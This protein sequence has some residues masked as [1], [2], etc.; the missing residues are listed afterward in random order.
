MPRP[1]AQVQPYVE[2][3]GAETAVTFLLA[4]G[5]AELTIAEEPTERAAYV[6]LIGLDKAKALAAVAHRLHEGVPLASKWLPVRPSHFP[7]KRPPL[8]AEV[9]PLPA[10]R[11]RPERGRSIDKYQLQ[12]GNP[13]NRQLVPDYYGRNCQT[14]GSNTLAVGEVVRAW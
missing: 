1:T 2:A 7:V 8:V 13:V 6:R 10:A 12:S 11:N 3:M 14:L 5:G 9:R 4:F